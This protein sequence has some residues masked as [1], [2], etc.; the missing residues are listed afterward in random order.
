MSRGFQTLPGA[1][2]PLTREVR[3]RALALGGLCGLLLALAWAVWEQQDLAL[4]QQQQSS[5]Q[6]E[7]VH[8][9]A[10]QARA[11]E[12]DRQA[13]AG[14]AQRLR[15]QAAQQQWL[16]SLAVLEDVADS[17]GVRLLQLRLDGQ[18]LQLQVETEPAQIQAWA[19]DRPALAWGLERPQIVELRTLPEAAG[20][21]VS[22]GV[23]R[24]P[25]QSGASTP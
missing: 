18:G 16:R 5:L 8:A 24:W 3:T 6:G 2:A 4:V 15:M 1:G 19:A 9:R 14:Q 12:Q 23:L 13:H 17:S 7:L 20:R 21:Q 22:R 10:L 25:V 11:A